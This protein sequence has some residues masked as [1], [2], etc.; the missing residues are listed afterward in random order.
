M[1]NEIVAGVDFGPGGSDAIAL[2]ADL[3]APG[4]R[5]T[6]TYVLPSD[7]RVFGAETESDMAAR[8]SVSRELLRR[9][10]ALLTLGRRGRRVRARRIDVLVV[11]AASVA[12]GLEFVARRRNADLIV[13]GASRRGRLERLLTGEVTGAVLT[14]ARCPVAVAARGGRQPPVGAPVVLPGGV[15]EWP[16]SPPAG[17]SS[18]RIADNSASTAPPAPN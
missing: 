5:L 10:N 14:R 12:R 18:A 15:S 2:A 8:M 11:P 17:A 13:L 6:L 1:F 3:V 7:P 9:E 16:E 4:G